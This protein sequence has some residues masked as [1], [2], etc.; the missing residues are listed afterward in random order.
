MEEILAGGGIE[1]A[2]QELEIEA[3]RTYKSKGDPDF[4]IWE[5]NKKDLRRL[6]NVYDWEDN[7]GW[8]CASGGRNKGTACDMVYIGKECIIGWLEYSKKDRFNSLLDYF[9]ECLHITDIEEVYEYAVYLAKT[10]GWT[11]ARLFRSCEG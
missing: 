2:F 11:V 4:E 3:K 6:A 1:N 9:K 7:W 10:N 5:L 8:F